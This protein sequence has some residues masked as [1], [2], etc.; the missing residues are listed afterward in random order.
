MRAAPGAK[1]QWIINPA[2]RVNV[3]RALAAPLIFFSPFV[4]WFSIGTQLFIF[5]LILAAI[6]DANYILHLHIHRPFSGRK[7]FNLILDLCLGSVT[8]MTS[9]N[10]RIQHFYGHHF[11]IDHAYRMKNARELLTYSARG[12][13][14]FSARSIWPTM[15]GP[16]VE[17][18]R[19]GIWSNVNSPLNYRW[20]FSEQT[21]LIALLLSL[22]YI[23]MRL[24]V[25][26]VIPWYILNCFISRYIDYLNHYGCNEDGANIFA[27]ANNSLSG[28]FNAT[29]HNFGYH[30]AHH[31]R[32]AAHWTDLPK[33]HLR[34]AGKIPPECL[35]PFSWSFLAFPYHFYLAR[36]GRM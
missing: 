3:A 36:A 13:F 27:C 22:L 17:A 35:K 23:N 6:C 16:Y 10:W 25:L 5:A 9:A 24:S 20:A 14:S 34:I 31:L 26:Y 29:T 7:S 2:D 18:W 11:G 28:W 30:T 15:V 4:I 12:A 19:K 8:G 21:L 1:G 33:I 32:P